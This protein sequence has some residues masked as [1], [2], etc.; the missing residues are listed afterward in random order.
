MSL[1]PD[2]WD[3]LKSIG[4]E[5]IPNDDARL[6]AYA[7]GWYY[8]I[9]RDNLCAYCNFLK[10]FIRIVDRTR[11]YHNVDI[12]DLNINTVQDLENWLRNEYPE[13]YKEE[14]MITKDNIEA[15]LK[16]NGIDNFSISGDCIQL[17]TLSSYKAVIDINHPRL[18]PIIEA[19]YSK[20][21][22]PLPEEEIMLKVGDEI[23]SFGCVSESKILAFDYKTDYI[24]LMYGGKI[25]FNDLSE[26]KSVNGKQG[27][28]VIPPFDFRKTLLDAGFIDD[29]CSYI[30]CGVYLFIEEDENVFFLMRG[31]R[32]KQSPANAAILIKASN[33]FGELEEHIS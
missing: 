19:H 27:K 4:F 33:S 28:F 18:T 21:L 3:Y 30:K 9:G 12:H 32:Y 26:I 31:H 23:A 11:N 1:A 17:D 8:T 7:G 24:H 20:K 6:G 15:L 22:E 5:D 14:D 25:P 13:F 2:M 29:N 16:H 10:D